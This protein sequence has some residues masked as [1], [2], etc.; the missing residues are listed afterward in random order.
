MERLKKTA[1]KKQRLTQKVKAIEV[2]A[3]KTV[4]KLLEEMS[5]TGFQGRNLA[6]VVDVMEEM[7]RDKNTTILLGYA[8]SL[9]TTGQWKIINWLIEN[10]FI[11][12][13]V[14]TGANIS[15]DIV[16]AMGYGYWQ[17]DHL[18]DNEEL[19]REGFNRYYDVY[20]KES[21][22]LEMTEL[23]ADFI[24]TLDEDY[25]YS[26]REFLHLF[27]RWLGQ[28]RI[29]S[30]VAVAAENGVPVFCPAIADSPYGDA[31][32]IAKSKGFN[33]TIDAIKDYVE[34][35]TLGEKVK[36]TGVIYIGGGVPKD[37][38]QLFAVT[39]D[40]LYKNREIPNRKDGLKRRSTNETYYPHKYA[41]Q[42]TTDS[43]QWGGLSGC[44]FEEA[45]SWGKESPTG[46]FIQCYCDATIA[47]P[48][49]AHALAERV[50]SRRKGTDFS[51]TFSIG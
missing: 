25:R 23:I 37:F 9:S 49:V 42:I 13:L 22:Y 17:G 29:R 11:D 45:V 36:N 44:T 21:D 48:I 19:F 31:A 2:E 34:F 28:K 30:I 27:G 14:P 6:R 40:L 41:V 51:R 12:I 24:V 38:I 15:E 7:I 47:L 10:R 16:D 8:G 20:G 3:P 1:E 43:P 50:R 46:R 5:R 18:V 4:S 32:L 33:L 26:S 35:M 39:G